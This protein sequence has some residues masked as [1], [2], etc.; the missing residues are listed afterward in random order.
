MR[1]VYAERRTHLIEAIER[2]YGGTLDVVGQQAGLHLVL[3]LDDG[4]D[5]VAIAREALELGII[6]RPLSLYYM[7]ASPRKGLLLGYAPLSK[8]QIDSGFAVLAEVIDKHLLPR[9]MPRQR[10]A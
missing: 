9:E 3:G 1:G 10:K 4:V 2:R 5:D 7:N 8:A 6:V